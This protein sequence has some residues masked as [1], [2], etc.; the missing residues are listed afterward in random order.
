MDL[1]VRQ[2]PQQEIADAVIPAGADEEVRVGH[3]RELQRVG[4]AALVDGID[5]QLAA[6]EKEILQV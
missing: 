1:G 2:V 3:A 6:K 5:S 4:E